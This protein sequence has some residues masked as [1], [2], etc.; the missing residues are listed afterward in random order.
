MNIYVY[1]MSIGSEDIVTKLVLF[2]IAI[3][4]NAFSEPL[5]SIVQLHK[6]HRPTKKTFFLSHRFQYDMI[7][8]GKW[9]YNPKIPLHHNLKIPLL[10]KPIYYN[11]STPSSF[12]VEKFGSWNHKSFVSISCRIRPGIYIPKPQKTTEFF[13]VFVYCW[14]FQISLN[15]C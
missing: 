3:R 6:L 8:R 7:V 15:A 10:R 2:I 14:V 11:L 4:G 1:L 9:R 5:V 12:S 13:R